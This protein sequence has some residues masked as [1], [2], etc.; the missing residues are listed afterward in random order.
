MFAL[1]KQYWK[2]K[3]SERED[4][5][6]FFSTREKLDEYLTSI[7]AFKRHWSYNTNYFLVGLRDTDFTVYDLTERIDLPGF[8]ELY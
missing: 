4:S 1:R 7:G 6:A 2:D 5:Y 8:I 3:Y